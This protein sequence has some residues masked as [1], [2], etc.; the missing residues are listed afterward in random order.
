MPVESLL[1]KN[2]VFTPL[3]AF[4]SEGLYEEQLQVEHNLDEYIRVDD[5]KMIR[6]TVN[7]LLEIERA[8]KLLEV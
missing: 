4:T 1:D 7:Y 2:L 5:R 3:E 8:W 6:W